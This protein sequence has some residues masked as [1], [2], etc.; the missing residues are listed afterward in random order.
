MEG[1]AIVGAVLAGG[2]SRRMGGGDKPLRLMGGRT[3]LDHVLDRFAPQCDALVLNANGDPRRLEQYRLP[4]VADPVE[5][6][7]G[8]LAGILAAL[9]WTA[10][11]RPDAPLVAT[12]PGD[13]P[14]LP[15][16]L[17]ERLLAA[18]RAEGTDIALAASAGRTHPVAGLWPVA[19]RE[20]LRRA[21]VAE[22][23]RK[24]SAWTA[25]HS[26]ALAAWPTEPVDPFFNVNAPDDL[27]QAGRLL[28][29]V[30]D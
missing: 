16:D 29:M 14:F 20:A 24:V 3:I 8:P 12:V 13:C 25:R 19:C 27:T 22:D 4:V 10:T 23:L 6:F 1:E 28:P 15:R 5:G 18:R 17:V 11:N 26:V 21:L 2:L 9:D 7:A 30:R